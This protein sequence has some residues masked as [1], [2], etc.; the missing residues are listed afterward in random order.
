MCRPT[1]F[2]DEQIE[3]SAYSM[4]FD[5]YDSEMARRMKRRYGREASA[6]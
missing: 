2:V 5:Y 1:L 6:I 3:G 4:V